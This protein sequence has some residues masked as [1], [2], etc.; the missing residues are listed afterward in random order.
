MLSP[1]EWDA[2]REDA[3]NGLPWAE[4]AGRAQE[5]WIVHVM[6]AGDDAGGSP[7]VDCDRTEVRINVD[8][9]SC[10]RGWPTGGGQGKQG[11]K[12]ESACSQPTSADEQGRS[13]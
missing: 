11:N 7:H 2:V 10:R 6:Q 1:P 4:W 12:G 8:L 3:R 5:N 13:T 9:G